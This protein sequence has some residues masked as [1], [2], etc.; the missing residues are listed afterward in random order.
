MTNLAPTNE[1]AQEKQL[2]DQ[3][4]TYNKRAHDAAS[5]LLSPGQLKKFDEY[6]QAQMTS[7]RVVIRSMRDTVP[8]K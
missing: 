4:E 2:L 1:D 6:Q 5:G 8:A 3:M 7:Q